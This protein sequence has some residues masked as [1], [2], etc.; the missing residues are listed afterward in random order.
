MKKRI[1]I[2]IMAHV[3]AGKTTLSEAFLYLSKSIRTL[4]RVDKKNT[5]LDNYE[6]ERRRGITI[7]SK[8]AHFTVKDTIVTLLDTPGHT[9]FAAEAERVLQV[10]DYCVLVVS[11]SD[12]VT[13]HTRTLWKLL[14]QYNIPTFI[15]VNKMD[16]PGCDADKLLSELKE[17]L[18][19]NIIPCTDGSFTDT[20]VLENIALCDED[21]MDKYL[22]NG[23]ISDEDI[24][25]MLAERKL[26]LCYFGSALKLDGLD[27][28]LCGLDRYTMGYAGTGD[29]FAAKVYKITRDEQGN[30]LTHL[31][32]TS[33]KLAARQMIE[34]VKRE[35]DDKWSE[36]VNQI[37]IYQGER[38][39]S[40]NECDA[41]QICAVS[42][43]SYTYPGQG[44]GCEKDSASPILA[45]V[46]TFRVIF[47]DGIDAK[48]MFPK[49]KL[50]SEEDPSLN[51][52]WNDDTKSVQVRLMGEVQ[53]QILKEII[54]N[55]FG[56]DV[57][58]GEGR[59]CYKETIKTTVEGVGHFEPLRHYAEVH[60]KLEPAERGSGLVFESD[61]SEDILA[62]NWQRLILTHLEEKNHQGVLTGSAVTDMKI[63][64]VNGRAHLK[65][66]EGGDFRQATYRAL[67]HGLMKAESVLLEPFYEF[68]LEIPQGSIG[69]AMSD[70]DRMNA[71]FKTPYTDGETA[72]ITG[73]A[74]VSVLNGYQQELVSYTKGSGTISFE[75]A[76]YYPCHNA[77][78]VIE[79]IGYNPELDVRNPAGSVFCANGAG[80]T[81]DWTEVEEYMHLENT[82]YVK[83]RQPD[84]NQRYG[85]ISYSDD[86]ELQDIFRRTYG[87]SGRKKSIDA[88]VYQNTAQNSEK[89]EQKK[90]A[91]PL[92]KEYLLVDGYNVIH[93]NE[94]LEKLMEISL[95]AARNVL[96]DILCNYRGFRNVEVILVFDAY[97]VKGNVGEIQNYNN[98]SVVYTKE[99]ETA[100]RYIERTAHEI[101]H[102]Y[103]TTVV[104]SDGLEQIIIRG[105]GCRAM[106][107]REFWEDVAVCEKQIKETLT[108]KRKASYE[109]KN[110]LFNYLSDELLEKL[111]KIRLGEKSL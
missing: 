1:T 90:T 38:F 10:L 33:G 24:K 106:S 15:F 59:I 54:K 9:D 4:G 66:T 5:I 48:L 79:K 85:N 78:E 18:S 92:M 83:P 99:A 84:I 107:S 69:H 104:T 22:E 102:D 62:K 37:R 98:I 29:E 19:G 3:D 51:I 26:F 39:E 65:H 44:L 27:E 52:E 111:E 32:V 25:K 56:I 13:G 89:Y 96:M 21:V 20:A 7:F 81:V 70:L 72:V 45:P 108:A 28:L 64:L 88:V 74:P 40:V 82:A 61:V 80:F 53:T 95:E 86:K 43:L 105:A 17:K 6:A 12:A 35:N 16:Q 76:G 11:A 87:E 23:D 58:F 63:T 46:M 2:G 47:E 8:Q 97:K 42:G 94:D 49:L 31:K 77:Q 41:G 68:R 60:L 36:K 67:R 55:R 103:N 14:S 34:G 73:I 30:R 50:L 100:D 109:G 57:E 91:S 101:C 93:S 110:Y 71:S 75:Y